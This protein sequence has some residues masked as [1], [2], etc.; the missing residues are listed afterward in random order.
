[1]TDSLNI[2]LDQIRRRDEGAIEALI[3]AHHQNL[4][5][6]IAAISTNVE[7]VD[8]V[9]QEVFLRAIQ[10]LDRVESL[11]DFPR[12]L[13]GIARNVVREQT[14]I[15]VRNSE[16]YFDFVDA[17]FVSKNDEPE[18]KPFQ[19]DKILDSLRVC[20]GKLPDKARRILT[21]RYQDE[22]NANE[23]GSSIGMTSGSVRI[24]LLRLR[25]TLLKCL[26]S[27]VG[28]KLTEAGL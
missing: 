8:D 12:F 25:E 14:R 10:R 21:L 13:R 11:E 16:R 23:I 19:D 26:R 3:A 18:D 28:G 24:S 1:M 4:R 6:Y 20:L 17:I 2:T 27:N 7:A 22:L 15:L 9:A 5:G